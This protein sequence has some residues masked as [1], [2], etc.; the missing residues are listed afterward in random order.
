MLDLQIRLGGLRARVVD[1][2]EHGPRRR[3]R[4]RPDLRLLLSELDDR[5]PDHAVS[6]PEGVQEVGQWDPAPH[7]HRRVGPD[8]REVLGR[9]RPALEEHRPERVVV[10]GGVLDDVGED[11]PVLDRRVA[12]DLGP[13][14]DEAALGELFAARLQHRRHSLHPGRLRQRHLVLNVTSPRP[15]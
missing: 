10:R 6:D 8:E 2:F 15:V 14:L 1:E 5:V 4:R 9:N 12:R 13:H 11:G 7:A 3:Q